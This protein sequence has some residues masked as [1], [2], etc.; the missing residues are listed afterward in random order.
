MSTPSLAS[1]L[2]RLQEQK[3]IPVSLSMEYTAVSNTLSGSYPVNSRISGDIEGV[4]VDLR[5]FHRSVP[6]ISGSFPVNTRVEGS[7]G[8]SAITA[9][10]KYQFVFSTL[11]GN[12]P[13]NT[14][15]IVQHEGQS[16]PLELTRTRM[17]GATR[18]PRGGGKKGGAVKTKFVAGQQ[19]EIGGGGGGGLAGEAG[20]P[21]VSGIKGTLAGVEF[22]IRFKTT[23]FCNT[24]SGRTPIANQA[25]GEIRL[26]A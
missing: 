7:I 19:V 4:P 22:D 21:I 23:Y 11:V 1:L 15:V 8:D 14:E 18:G 2:T 3:T 24:S 5:L 9:E 25:I 13:V 16:Y 12:I 17:V 10:M 20:I 26:A 6:N